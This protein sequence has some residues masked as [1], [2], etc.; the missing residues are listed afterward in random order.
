MDPYSGAG[1]DI[2][3]PRRPDGPAGR[4]HLYANTRR[5]RHLAAALQIPMT[6]A[7]PEVILDECLAERLQRVRDTAEERDV[8]VVRTGIEEVHVRAGP[9]RLR[10]ILQVLLEGAMERAP[11]GEGLVVINVRHK[12]HSDQ[13]QVT[14][15]DNGRTLTDAELARA[16]TLDTKSHPGL[17]PTPGLGFP[18]AVARRLARQDG[19][20]L[21]IA[22]AG[23]GGTVVALLL[24]L[25]DATGGEDRPEG[26]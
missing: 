5:L 21:H 8:S 1:G 10:H 23:G 22:P 26:G 3:S 4:R 18:L 7:N 6:R 14:I 15:S 24:P 25:A 17:R 2:D 13:V 12:P 9:K 19:G 16:F 11:R 20:E